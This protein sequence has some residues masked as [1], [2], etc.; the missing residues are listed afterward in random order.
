MKK[1]SLL[2]LLFI[3]FLT[4]NSQSRSGINFFIGYGYYEGMNVG[5]E[6]LL[7]SGKS[8]FG[9]SIGSDYLFDKK[10]SYIAL[11]PEYN[12]AIFRLKK[13]TE[14][15]FKWY[16]NNKLIYW[17][18]DDG[19]YEWKVIS[20]VPSINRRYSITQKLNLSV[21]AGPCFNIVLYNKRKTFME[22]GWP[23]HVLPNMR[24]R[25]IF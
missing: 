3:S 13:I 22:V 7:N 20:L 25:L 6:Y 21:D 1:A 17:Q 18:L 15:T 12:L 23:Y 4:L 11:M 16:I 8:S 5:T 2:I 10:K 19:Y 14:I 24:V 9:F